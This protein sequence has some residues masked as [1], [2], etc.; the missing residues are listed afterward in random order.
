MTETRQ[1]AYASRS[2]ERAMLIPPGV[3]RRLVGVG[4]TMQSQLVKYS[5]NCRVAKKISPKTSFKP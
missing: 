5:I 4:E 1:A 3:A 2:P